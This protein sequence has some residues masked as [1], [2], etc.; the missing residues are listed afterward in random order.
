MTTTDAVI[1]EEER[2]ESNT[3]TSSSASCWQARDTWWKC[4]DLYDNCEW[5]CHKQ[6]E[7]LRQHCTPQMVSRNHNKQKS[8]WF[9]LGSILSRTS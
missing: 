9:I 8:D 5:K 4:L 2:N 6:I 3:S 7:Q 1:T